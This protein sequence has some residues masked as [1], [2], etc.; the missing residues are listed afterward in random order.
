MLDDG[1][2]SLSYFHKDSV[3]SCKEINKTVIKNIVIKK[4][5]IKKSVI[6]E[7]DRDD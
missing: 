7:K 6:T 3:A 4:I 2:C 1:I 5:A